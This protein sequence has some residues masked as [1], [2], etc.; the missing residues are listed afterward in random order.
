MKAFI[1]TDEDKRH[2]LIVSDY[3]PELVIQTAGDLCGRRLRRDNSDD[4]WAL[5]RKA[6]LLRRIKREKLVA[7]FS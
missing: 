3:S 4:R 5:T 7:Q 6:A 1:L 2:D